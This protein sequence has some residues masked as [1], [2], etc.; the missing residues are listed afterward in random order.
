[1]CGIATLLSGGLDSSLITGVVA[2]NK[3]DRLTTFSIDYE[4][5]DKYFKRKYKI[6][7]FNSLSW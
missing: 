4:E 2:K 1:M 6:Y 5:N 7:I 3:E